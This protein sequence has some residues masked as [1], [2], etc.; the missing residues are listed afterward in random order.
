MNKA[1][2]YSNQT[3]SLRDT[4]DFVSNK[5]QRMQVQR[6]GGLN[7]NLEIDCIYIFYT[8]TLHLFTCRHLSVDKNVAVITIIFPNAIQ[9]STIFA[10]D[11]NGEMRKGDILLQ[12]RYRVW[13]S[14]RE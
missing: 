1:F 9:I 4:A 10:H 11:K 13:R 5:K 2:F 3:L 6:M 12:S 14:H 7:R 8:Y